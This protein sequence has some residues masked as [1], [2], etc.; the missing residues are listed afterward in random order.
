MAGPDSG[1]SDNEDSSDREFVQDVFK[2][3]A[4]PRRRWPSDRCKTRRPQSASGGTWPCAASQADLERHGGKSSLQ[5][6]TNPNCALARQAAVRAALR[7][8]Y[9]NVP[10]RGVLL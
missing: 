1:A 9:Q 3:L 10:R 7:A 8:A 6:L 2:D 5:S 4:V